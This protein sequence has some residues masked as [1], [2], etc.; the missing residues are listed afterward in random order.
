VTA[1]A[2]LKEGN[3]VLGLRDLPKAPLMS[4][5]TQI[6]IHLAQAKGCEKH[7]SYEPQ[8]GKDRD[9]DGSIGELSAQPLEWTHASAAFGPRAVGLP[10]RLHAGG[11][12]PVAGAGQRARDVAGLTRFTRHGAD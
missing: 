3:L 7:A 12:P 5:L 2:F 10:H 9:D 11:L 6:P 8:N 1:Q 4:G